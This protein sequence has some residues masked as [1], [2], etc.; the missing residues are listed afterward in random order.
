MSKARVYSC[1]LRSKSLEK[2]SRGR[3]NGIL[4]SFMSPLPFSFFSPMISVSFALMHLIERYCVSDSRLHI[5]ETLAPTKD[6][7]YNLV[8]SLAD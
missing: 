2:G 3:N 4:H 7:T 8:Y 5:S 6:K 1:F